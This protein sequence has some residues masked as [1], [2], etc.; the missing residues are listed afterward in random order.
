MVW[1]LVPS[2]HSKRVPGS[3]PCWGHSV[4][5]LHVLPMYTSVLSGYYGLH[6]RLIGDSKLSLGVTV[7]MHGCVS[8]LSLCGRVMDRRPIQGVPCL[9]P[10]DRWDRLQPICDLTD[11]LSGYRKWMDGFNS[12]NSFVN[13]YEFTVI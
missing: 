1:W 3:N 8:R 12:I 2:P 4:W 9:L 11:G 6:V 10:D 13:R 5:S 7:S